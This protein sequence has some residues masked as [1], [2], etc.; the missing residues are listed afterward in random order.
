MVVVVGSGDIMANGRKGGME[1]IGWVAA[2]AC[3]RYGGVRAI[4]YYYWL[5]GRACLGWRI[6]DS[7][8]SRYY[9]DR[10]QPDR[11]GFGYGRLES[12]PGLGNWYCAITQTRLVKPRPD[13][14]ER[15][16]YT[17]TL[18]FDMDTHISSPNTLCNVPTCIST[19]DSSTHC[20]PSDLERMRNF[21]RK[22]ENIIST[23]SKCVQAKMLSI[24]CYMLKSLLLLYW[25]FISESLA[26]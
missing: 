10:M 23:K 26:K 17:D 6:W 1:A 4:V 14:L 16:S 11:T 9:Q 24:D 3:A 15:E 19:G 13:Q 7:N 5:L 21:I 18:I 20:K 2:E 12:I 22:L 25:Q 8:W